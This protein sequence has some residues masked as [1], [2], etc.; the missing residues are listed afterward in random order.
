MADPYEKQT[1]RDPGTAKCRR[2]DIFILELHRGGRMSPA[3]MKGTTVK[4]AHSKFP[5]KSSKSTSAPN[6]RVELLFEIGAEEIPA[7]M[8]ARAVSEL[9][10]ILDKHLVAE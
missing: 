6:A 4:P 8:L 2:A 7:G 9:K 10:T 1:G 5:A 3:A